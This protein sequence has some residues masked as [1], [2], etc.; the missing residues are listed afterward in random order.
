MYINK[1]LVSIFENIVEHKL[2]YINFFNLKIK[3]RIEFRKPFIK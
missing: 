1:L 3:L 2:V